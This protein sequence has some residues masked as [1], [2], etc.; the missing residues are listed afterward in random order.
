MFATGGH[1]GLDVRLRRIVVVCAI[2]STSSKW[3]ALRELA[4]SGVVLLDVPRSP[5]HIVIVHGVRVARAH[6]EVIRLLLRSLKVTLLE[7][8]L[9]HKAGIPATVLVGHAFGQLVFSGVQVVN[10]QRVQHALNL[11]NSL[12]LRLQHGLLAICC[13]EVVLHRSHIGH[14]FVEAAVVSK[15]G[16]V[17]LLSLRAGLGFEGVLSVVTLSSNVAVLLEEL[18]TSVTRAIESPAAV[19]AKLFRILVV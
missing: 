15:A 3:I 2:I 12:G 5:R 1:A 19:I 13:A 7:I 6:A 11:C 9:R 14:G 8:Q 10:S 17:P 18:L 4:T 16:T